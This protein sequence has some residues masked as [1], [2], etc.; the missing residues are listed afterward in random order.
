MDENIWNR[1]INYVVK[2]IG[3]DEWV[4][5]VAEVRDQLATTTFDHL[6]KPGY[7]CFAG[8]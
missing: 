6:Y 4:S 3:L 2:E 7:K 1:A 8:N 5:S